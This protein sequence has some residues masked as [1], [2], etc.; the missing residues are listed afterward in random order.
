MKTLQRTGTMKFHLQEF[1]FDISLKANEGWKYLKYWLL[2]KPSTYGC[3]AI[4]KFSQNFRSLA[5]A[6]LCQER[7]F[8]PNPWSQNTNHERSQYSNQDNQELAVVFTFMFISMGP[9]YAK[10][11]LRAELS[12]TV[13]EI[14]YAKS[15]L[16]WWYLVMD[17]D[18]TQVQSRIIAG[19]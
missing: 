8:I 4:V 14:W 9:Q 13:N 1:S 2:M 11:K 16:K 17:G 7:L 15:K 18:R 5:M 3:L 19:S 10:Q 12:A 6:E